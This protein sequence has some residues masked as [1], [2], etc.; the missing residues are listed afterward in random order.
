[1]RLKSVW[2]SQADRMRPSAKRRLLALASFIESYSRNGD[3][4]CIVIA[5]KGDV[6]SSGQNVNFE[7]TNTKNQGSPREVKRLVA[8]YYNP[9]IS[10]IR[11]ARKPVIALVNGP[12]S[13]TAANIA[14]ACDITLAADTAYFAQIFSQLGLI[15]DAGGT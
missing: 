1:G 11:Y 5:A 3:T 15:P 14:L 8:D 6:F 7:D 13:D 12:A 2:L 9:L 4:R 10:A